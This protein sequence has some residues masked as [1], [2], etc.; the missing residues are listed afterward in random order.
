M[1]EIWKD[2][3]FTDNKYAVSNLGNV[4]RNEHYTTIGPTKNRKEPSTIFYK[5]RLVTKYVGVDGYE[6]VHITINKKTQPYK[7]HRLVANAFIPNPHDLPQVNHIDE[8]PKNNVVTNLEWCT[9]KYNA[10]YGTR[11]NR[12]RIANGKKVGQFDKDWNL[13]KIWDSLSEAAKHFKASTTVYI[14]RVCKCQA[15]R[16]TYKGFRWKYIETKT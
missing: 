13:I 8:N 9:A 5:E 7:V 12:L 3:E 1:N 10:N 14:S 16:K 4:K 11:N 2:I 15:G 6:I